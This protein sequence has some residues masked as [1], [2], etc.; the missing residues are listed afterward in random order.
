MDDEHRQR[1]IKAVENF[2][3]KQISQDDLTPRKYSHPELK[4][5]AEIIKWCRAQGISIDIVDAASAWERGSE[6]YSR[7]HVRS[8]F[9]DA[10]GVMANGR[11]IYIEFKAPGKRCTLKEHQREFLIEKINNNAFACCTD[12]IDHIK[13]LLFKWKENIRLRYN[14]NARKILIDDLHQKKE[15]ELIF[16]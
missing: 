8:G 11:A 1:I 4:T 2:S 13:N 10:V 5:Q 6:S 16:D 9:S 15:K 14:E 12:S 3:K 7:T